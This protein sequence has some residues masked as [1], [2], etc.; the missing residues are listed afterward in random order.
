MLPP[1][2][3]QQWSIES[4]ADSVEVFA[5]VEYEV[6]GIYKSMGWIDYRFPQYFNPGTI[7]V[8]A[9]ATPKSGN[10]ELNSW[11]TPQAMWGFYLKNPDDA[12]AFLTSLPEDLRDSV[13]IVDQGYSHVKPL[14]AELRSNARTILLITLA[15]WLAVV[16]IFLFIYVFRAKHTMGTLRSLGMPKRKVFSV[17][18]LACMALW[19]VG[20]VISG[21]ASAFLY[22]KLEAQAFQNV[23]QSGAYN[24]AFSDIVT[25]ADQG[26]NPWTGET[27]G[28]T[29][30]ALMQR[31]YSAGVAVPRV[32][33]SLGI[34]GV[35]FLGICAL[36]IWLVSRKKTIRLLKG[37]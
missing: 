15:V 8:S 33:L 3:L 35:L 18:L 31:V 14:L 36:T 28:L 23:F 19:L 21:I 27:D 16:G 30:D 4:P 24:Q 25:G 22:D 17:F 20:A 32:L 29:G 5:E 7:F 12:D 11:R 37:T 9:A 34:Q 1:D 10:E 6:V 2:G 26:T 13:R